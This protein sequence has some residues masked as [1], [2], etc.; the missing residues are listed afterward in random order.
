[1]LLNISNE[2]FKGWNP[3]LK[4]KALELYGQ[5]TDIPIPS[6]PPDSTYT[7][8]RQMALS[9]YQTLAQNEPVAVLASGGHPVFLY[10][11]LRVLEYKG[12][13][14]ITP[15]FTLNAKIPVL[16]S[17][18][19]DFHGFMHYYVTNQQKT[20]P[21]QPNTY[22][23]KKKS[24]SP[25]PTQIEL[26][27]NQ[28]KVLKEIIH[29]IE[30]DTQSKIFILHG[31]AG[32]GKTTL[33]KNLTAHLT[34]KEKTVEL[35]ATTGRAASI[36]SQKTNHA[37]RT[38]HSAI[39][40]YGGIREV[41]ESGKD[42]WKSDSGQLFLSFMPKGVSEKQGQVI[43]VDEAS[44]ISHLPEKNDNPAQYGSGAV[45]HDLLHQFQN[46]KIIMVG[47]HC[48]LPPVSSEPFSAAL[49]KKYL[50]NV[51]DVKVRE[52]WLREIHR[53]SQEPG[54][55]IIQIASN[56]RHLIE[57][58]SPVKDFRLPPSLPPAYKILS[59]NEMIRLY[60]TALKQGRFQEQILIVNSNK[61]AFKFNMDIKKE[62]KYY[63]QRGRSLTG[64][65]KHD[66]G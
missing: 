6:V 66:P 20:I 44:M 65:S 19:M 48:Q 12:V 8:I 13:P 60:T 62:L 21:N 58:R 11:L 18:A 37:A 16:V 10:F 40:T 49:S 56:F 41:E 15:V 34:A 47:D 43:V 29:F 50:E 52:G 46:S 14:C 59:T 54:N 28:K 63:P 42:A 26:T 9:F 27:E 51:F 23:V 5:V 17:H 36:L 64:S 39:Y 3:L 61:F 1:M 38:V 32:T 57:N 25:N 22:E 35:L 55:P 45:L 4:E 24:E 7:D 30:D 33:I 53:Q 31:Y 2:E